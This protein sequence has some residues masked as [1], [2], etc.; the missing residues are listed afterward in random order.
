MKK[1]IKNILLGGTIVGCLLSG[2]TPFD[3]LNADPTRLNEANPG[4]FL[5]PIL[6]NISINWSSIFSILYVGLFYFSSSIIL[7]K[8][9]I[10]SPTVKEI[11]HGAL[12]INGSQMLKPWKKRL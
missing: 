7:L 2:C 10:M 12:T 11:I 3:E 4:S 8:S 5:D 9:F 1:S 6:Y